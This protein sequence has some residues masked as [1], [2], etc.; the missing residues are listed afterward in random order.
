[1]AV[2]AT[3][4]VEW[5]VLQLA[6][7]KIGAVLVPIEP[8]AGAADLAHVLTDADVSTLVFVDRVG[9]V[10]LRD[11]FLE[12]CPEARAGRPGHLASRR[13]SLLKR[14]ALLGAGDAQGRCSRGP[15]C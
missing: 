12:C 3:N 2:F 14:V 5:V 11:V 4:R 9:D 15:T 1:V 10:S 7:A 6:V 8:A 13:F